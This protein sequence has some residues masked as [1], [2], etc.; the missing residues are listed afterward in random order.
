MRYLCPKTDLVR[1][2]K[3]RLLPAAA[4]LAVA[5]SAASTAAAS[6]IVVTAPTAFTA[7]TAVVAPIA[8]A[9]AAAVAPNAVAASNTA[10][11]PT[12]AVAPPRRVGHRMSDREFA[13]LCERIERKPFKSE[14]LELVEVGSL[15]SRFSCEQVCRLLAFFTFDDD[16]L[17]ALALL[18]PH[19][20]DRPHAEHLVDC[21]TFESAKQRALLLLL[22]R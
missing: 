14:R 7:P 8:A 21:F 3:K 10:A 15:D 9:S 22:E 5:I 12:A 20:V 19:I 17:A 6:P 13:V 2:M 4:A 16:R 18:A 1:I 11:V